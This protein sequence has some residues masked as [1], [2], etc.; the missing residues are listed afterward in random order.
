MT[1]PYPSAYLLDEQ[2]HVPDMPK[3]KPGVSRSKQMKHSSSANAVVGNSRP[4]QG[5]PRRSSG[6]GQQPQQPRRSRNMHV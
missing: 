3:L 2:D 6:G 4:S 1:R 5:A